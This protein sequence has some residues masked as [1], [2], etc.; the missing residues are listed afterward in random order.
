MVAASRA[1][2]SMDCLF[3][4]TI[5]RY[6]TGLIQITMCTVL[7]E[8]FYSRPSARESVIFN[9]ECIRNRLSAGLCLDPLRELPLLLTEP[10]AVFAEGTQDREGTQTEEMKRRGNGRKE[11]GTGKGRKG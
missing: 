7:S 1:S 10:L 5:Y 8:N 9:S 6:A 3:R 2:Q 4:N 11:E